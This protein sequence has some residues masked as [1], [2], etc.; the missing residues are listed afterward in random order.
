MKYSLASIATFALASWMLAFGTVVAQDNSVEDQA[1]ALLDKYSG[2]LV[3]VTVKGE[4]TATTTGDPLPPGLT[5]S[6]LF[7][8]V[9][10]A[11]SGLRHSD[12]QAAPSDFQR[13]CR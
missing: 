9:I 11:D 5:G 6:G 10:S 3:V 1:R 12:D 2:A 7:R 8:V 13:P 4:L